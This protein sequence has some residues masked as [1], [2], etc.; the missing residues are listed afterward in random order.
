MLHQSCTNAGK[1]ALRWID[2]RRNGKQGEVSIAWPLRE[3]L[4]P[5]D[6]VPVGAADL[7]LFSASRC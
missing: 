6:I 5:S 7:Q 1:M 2:E 4:Y 3:S